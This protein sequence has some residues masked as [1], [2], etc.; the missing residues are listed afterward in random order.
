MLIIP[1][2]RIQ[3]KT[4]PYLTELTLKPNDMSV[5]INLL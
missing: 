5:L 4:L 2:Y 1:D 3:R